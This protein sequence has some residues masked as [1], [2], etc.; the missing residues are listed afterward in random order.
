MTGSE[1]RK[2]VAD[3]RCEVGRY[4]A[5]VVAM[6]V[7]GRT[8]EP[9]KTAPAWMFKVDLDSWE[10]ADLS[11]LIDEAHRRADQHN[12]RFDRIRQTAQVVLPIG[13][14]LTVVVGSE[15]GRLRAGPHDKPIWMIGMWAVAIVFVVLGTLGAAAIIVTKSTF[16]SVQPGVLAAKGPVDV[17]RRLATELIA[18]LAPGEDAVNTRLTMQWW[19][20]WF[21]SVGAIVHLVLWAIQ[22]AGVSA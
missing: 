12:A 16:G 17:Q 10:A 2:R 6:L 11:A 3:L 8:V 5:H 21:L 20:V 22:A 19:S 13:I 1:L 4:L 9:F 18:Q 15:L 14:A 7:P